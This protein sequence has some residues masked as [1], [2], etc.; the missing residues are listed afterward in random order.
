MNEYGFPTYEDGSYQKRVQHIELAYAS[1][2]GLLV[3][4]EVTSLLAGERGAKG[5]KEC[6]PPKTLGFIF[7]VEGEQKVDLPDRTY[8]LTFSFFPLA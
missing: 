2:A 8:K 4:F 3:S 1:Y 5:T 7:H 6:A